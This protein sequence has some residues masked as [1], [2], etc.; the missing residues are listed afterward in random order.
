MKVLLD[1][2]PAGA[3]AL[4]HFSGAFDADL[5]RY[6]STATDPGFDPAPDGRHPLPPIDR[7]ARQLGLWGIG[8]DTEVLVYDGAR[9]AMGACRLWW[10]L[11]AS[12]HKRVDILDGGIEA[13]KASG[14]GWTTESGPPPVPRAPYPVDHWS[15]PTVDADEVAVFVFDPARL[16]IDVRSPERWRGEVESL[17]PVAGHIPG[18]VNFFLENNLTA[19]GRFKTA[20]ELRALYAPL[21]AGRDPSQVAVHCGSGVSACHTLY[22]LDRV[23][24]SGASLYVGSYSQWCR[25]GRPIATE[26]K[27]T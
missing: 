23:G 5:D 26:Q 16:L 3:W 20:E 21:L 27:A 4:G 15:W 25:T 7:W 22:A 2:R 10:M 9:G 13:G 1:A 6:L 12:G 19:D 18:S 11:K 24:F 17:D 14:M 8:P